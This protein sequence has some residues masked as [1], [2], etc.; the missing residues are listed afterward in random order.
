MM[1]KTMIITV[2]IM[3]TKMMRMMI[4]VRKRRK[5]TRMIRIITLL[6]LKMVL[7]ILMIIT[8][9]RNNDYNSA[10]DNNVDGDD[11]DDDDDNNNN[12]T[13][14]TTNSNNDIVT[15]MTLPLPVLYLLIDHGYQDGQQVDGG[16]G[17]GQVV[18]HLLDVDEHLAAVGLFDHRYPSDGHTHHH[19]DEE[20]D[21]KVTL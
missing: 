9:I 12:N 19:D 2:M 11:D 6:L 10:Y 13:T 21:I 20:S 17:R 7:M 5:M 8:D 4:L 16:E 1:P 18:G 15:T 14:T 3:I